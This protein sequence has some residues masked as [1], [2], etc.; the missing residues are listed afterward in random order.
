[1][2]D[3]VQL[4]KQ[5]WPLIVVQAVVDVP[6]RGEQNISSPKLLL[7]LD[8]ST[9]TVKSLFDSNKKVLLYNDETE[10]PVLVSQKRDASEE[11]G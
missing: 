2:L 8:I 7:N 10:Q 11:E 9:G 6:H 4:D 3:K 1:V 5:S